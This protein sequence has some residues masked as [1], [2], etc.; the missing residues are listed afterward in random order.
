MGE[1]TVT[2]AIKANSTAISKQTRATIL[3]QEDL[4]L[5]P[6]LMTDLRIWDSFHTLLGATPTSDDD[7][8]LVGGTFGTAPPLIQ[9]GDVK[10]VTKT[11]YARFLAVV[12]ECYVAG[13]TFNL[14]MSAGI[15]TTVADGSC[16]LDLVAYRL[17][18]DS[19]ISA[20]LC[21]T[22][23]QSINSLT[24]ADKS[25][26]IAPSTLTP[27]DILD[28]RIVIASVDTATATAVIP[29]VASI[30]IACDIKG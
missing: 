22:A 4:A 10:T 16:T 23:A 13:E 18:K 11:R 26:T 14:V 1:L 20:D 3:V 19:G 21:S 17:D 15:I 28:C 25:F 12:P 8:A 6:V 9:T 7:L 30:D 24:F 5:F 2:G 29:T 27:G